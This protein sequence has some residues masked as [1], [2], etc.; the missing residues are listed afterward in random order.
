MAS[1]TRFDVIRRLASY[2]R[3]TCWVCFATDEDEPN[4]KWVQPCRCKGTTRWVHDHCLQRWFDEKQHGNPTLKVFCP[5]CKT[6]YSIKYPA[7]NNALVLI[8]SFHNFLD[9]VCPFMLCSFAFLSVFWSAV[10][11]G[12]L[13]LVQIFGRKDW[14]GILEKSDRKFLLFALPT[15]PSALLLIEMLQWEDFVLDQWRKQA[16]KWWILR[17]IFNVDCEEYNPLR[18]P[19]ETNSQ[20]D[21]VWKT[22]VV[23]GAFMLPTFATTMG[24]YL[25]P[26]IDSPLK[27]ALLGGITFLSA[28][29]VLQIYYKQQQ[30][31]RLANREI[32]DFDEDACN[33]DDDDGDDDL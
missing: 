19:L 7:L 22:R 12:G 20:V 3:R 17:K 9:K 21:L 25:F 16:K 24:N 28:K 31:V 14:W 2:E 4:L 6:E 5:Q 26:D 1:D 29:G 32:Q 23:C 18:L 27:K 10:G 13:A 33:N 30:Y 15:I 11:F 8:D